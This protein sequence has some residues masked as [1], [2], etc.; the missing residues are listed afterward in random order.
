M[1]M[2]S[3]PRLVIGTI[4]LFIGAAF[5]FLAW[6][7]E[8]CMSGQANALLTSGAVALVANFVAWLMLG[9][10][11]PSKLVLFVSVLPTVAALMYSW[12]T[13]QLTFGYLSNGRGACALITA[14]PDAGADGR[15]LVFIILWLLVCAS[16]WSGFI[17]VV[18][19]AIGVWKERSA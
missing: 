11:V 3:W 2:A 16:F 18:R 8:T 9:R 13:L 7:I 1:S 5:G 17:P 6:A 14:D 12:S 15:E 4:L 10:R 19:R